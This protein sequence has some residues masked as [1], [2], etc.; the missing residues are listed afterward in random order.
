VRRDYRR[1]GIAKRLCG[2]AERTARGWGYSEVLLKVEADNRK[3]R[4]LYRSL[5]YRVVAVDRE[6]ERPEA[7]AVGLQF[8]PT[9]QVAMRKDLRL[10]PADV[11]ALRTALLGGGYYLY[12]QYAAAG[13]GPEGALSRA[14][15]ATGFDLQ[16]LLPL[17]SAIDDALASLLDLVTR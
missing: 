14:E 1:K 12:T 10:P 13:L 5:G 17:L 8:V 3:A 11:L 15:E 4:N 9:T 6:A 7:S 16:A 2:F